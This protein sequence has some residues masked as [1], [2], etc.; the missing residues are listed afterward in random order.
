MACC[1]SCGCGSAV[2]GS[3]TSLNPGQQTVLSG[4]SL[5]TM[6]ANPGYGRASFT[7]PAVPRI[8]YTFN[9]NP[10]PL[11]LFYNRWTTGR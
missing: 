11:Q 1:G 5:L 9:P 8:Q 6:N 10:R 4:E 3:L 2:T 7:F